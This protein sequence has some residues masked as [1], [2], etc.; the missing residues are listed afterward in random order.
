MRAVSPA[1]GEAQ[2]IAQQLRV[3]CKRS[4]A[5][6]SADSLSRVM[7]RALSAKVR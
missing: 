7:W 1:E 4:S 6:P 3:W 2:Y 5:Q